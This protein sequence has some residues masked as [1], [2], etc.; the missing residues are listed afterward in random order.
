MTMLLI[1]VFT[2]FGIHT[3]LWLLRLTVFA[4]GSPADSAEEEG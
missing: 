3:A 1:G 4:D 2:V